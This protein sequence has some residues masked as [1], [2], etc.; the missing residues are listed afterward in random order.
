MKRPWS[1]IAKKW[2]LGL[3]CA[4]AFSR[5]PACAA[6]LADMFS[7]RQTVTDGNGAIAGD[8]LNATAEPKEP[9]H[10]GKPASHS[11]WVAWIAPYDGIVTFSTDGSSYDTTLAAYTLDPGTKPAMERLR[12]AAQND[13]AT[14][15]ISTSLIQFGVTA[16]TEY[17]IAVDGA[18]GAT[19]LIQLT[20]NFVAS[21]DPPAIILSVP[22]DH[23]LR[24]GDTLTLSVAF[25]TSKSVHLAWFFNDVEILNSDTPTLTIPN[26]QAENAG[27]Y[28]LRITAGA[29]RMFTN[30]IEIQINSEGLTA[31]LARNHLFDALNS[32]LDDHGQ[33]PPPA[34]PGRLRALAIGVTRGYNGSQVFNTVFADLDPNEPAHCGVTGGA[35][36]WLAYVA[37]ASGVAHVDTAG[38]AFDTV[39]AVYTHNGPLTGYPDLIPVSCDDNSGP[40]GRTSA[41]RFNALA[42]REYL[43]VVDG[44]AGARGIAYINYHLQAAPAGVAPT[45]TQQPASQT[46]ALGGSTAFTVVAAGDAP[47][48]YAWSFQNAPLPGQTGNSLP[49]SNAQLAQSGDYSVVVSNP[50]G[51]VQSVTAALTVVP[52]PTVSALPASVV[53]FAGESLSLAPVATG[54][55][56]TGFQWLKDGA[57]LGGQNTPQLDIPSLATADAGIYSLVVSNVAGA[58]QSDPVTV[59]VLAADPPIISGPP[60]SQAAPAG[61]PVTFQV[62]AGGTPPL[63]Y[64]WMF[65]GAVMAGQTQPILTI[66]SVGPADEGTYIVAVSNRFGQVSATATLTVV[67]PP[68]LG[69]VPTTI[70]KLL[71][72]TLTLPVEASGTA[73]LVFAWKRNDVVLTNQAGASLYLPNLTLEDSGN[74]QLEVSNAAGSAVTG[75]IALQV[76]PPQIAILPS[77]AGLILQFPVEPGLHYR[78]EESRS[79]GDG[80]WT[81]AQEGIGLA[82]ALISVTNSPGAAKTIFYRAAY[83]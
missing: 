1:L 8:N 67:I 46:I 57:A 39:L 65:Q 24:F 5:A 22:P 32:K 61:S 9:A 19:G 23:S 78:I 77:G 15:D 37:P 33:D 4:L 45:I 54:V 60:A 34:A 82:S 75:L 35:S 36:Y 40:D 44:V 11:M 70:S 74:Y 62:T 51:T 20:Y 6:T 21:S 7:D 26:F 50:F 79:L 29:V 72:S 81:L 76:F 13:N 64:A 73:P 12:V 49:I 58:V 80:A 28:K 53:K 52:L 3:F 41:L 68:A 43:I 18:N 56:I 42:G 38:S 48:S 17:E 63:S 2:F 16:G 59:T 55:M 47:L 30:P 27:L 69:T 83:R 25:Q 10:G 71:G 14:R 31:T 66:P